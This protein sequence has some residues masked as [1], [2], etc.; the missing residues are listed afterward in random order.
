M[1]NSKI[2]ELYN[3]CWEPSVISPGMDSLNPHKFAQLI[4]NECVEIVKKSASI[5]NKS[6]IAKAEATRIIEKIQEH[7]L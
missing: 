6:E 2:E 4:I 5:H 3:Q 7:F 1:M